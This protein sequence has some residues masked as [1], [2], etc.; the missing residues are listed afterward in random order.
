MLCFQLDRKD[1]NI[2]IISIPNPNVYKCLRQSGCVCD[3]FRGSD[4]ED[5]RTYLSMFFGAPVSRVFLVCLKFKFLLFPTLF[6]HGKLKTKF[7][8]G[9]DTK[10]K[11]VSNKANLI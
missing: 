4:R 9:K 8:L 7:T 11:G 6:G 1:L 2:V 10:K 3:C 5:T